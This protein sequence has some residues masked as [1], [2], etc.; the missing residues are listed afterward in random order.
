MKTSRTALP[1]VLALLAGA[2]ASTI[3]ESA[4]PAARTGGTE[5]GPVLTIEASAA[6]LLIERRAVGRRHMPLPDLEIRATLSVRC[7]PGS[8]PAT[9]SLMSADTRVA[10]SGLADQEAQDIELMLAVP[11][12]QLP[13]VY[14]KDFCRESESGSPILVKPALV[15]LQGSLRCSARPD[16]ANPTGT[17]P[18]DG[19]ARASAAVDVELRCEPAPAPPGQSDGDTAQSEEHPLRPNQRQSIAQ[20]R[21]TGDSGAVIRE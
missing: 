7:G 2:T 16:A 1:C 18:A 19:F 12:A 10:A 6:P 20:P 21:G 13:P 8:A 4:E 15:S 5:P 9:V 17:Q 11:A 14:S 3:S